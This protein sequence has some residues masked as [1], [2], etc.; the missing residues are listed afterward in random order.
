MGAPVRHPYDPW[1]K[2]LITEGEPS[3]ESPDFAAALETTKLAEGA[4]LVEGKPSPREG[5][6]IEAGY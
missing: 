5:R 6:G 2:F 1:L 4:S 3:R